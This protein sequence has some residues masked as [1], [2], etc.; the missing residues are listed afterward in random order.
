MKI[1]KSSFLSGMS[2]SFGDFTICQT[3]DGP[4]LKKKM[5]YSASKRATDPRYARVRVNNA[6]FGNAGRAVKLVRAA[7]ASQLRYAKDAKLTPRMQKLMLQVVKSDPCNERGSR[8]AANGD[9]SF[10]QGFEC[11]A[12]ANLALLP[13][14]DHTVNINRVSGSVILNMPS[15]KP[16]SN[17]L[18]PDKATHFRI[19]C[20]VSEIDFADSSYTTKESNS[21]LLPIN[22]KPTG[23]IQLSTA[24]T[25]GSALPVFIAMGI[26]FV[27]MINGNEFPFESRE[28]NPLCFVKIERP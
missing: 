1:I 23:P 26:Q 16:K 5:R 10:L 21:G 8:T 7:F 11:N 9:L 17:V 4:I 14:A 27:E 6:D 3:K 20:A 18:Y 22:N 25:T 19:L 28:F 12:D 24:I 2:G 13:A 15:L